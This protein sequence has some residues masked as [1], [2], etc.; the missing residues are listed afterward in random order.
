MLFEKSL[1][2]DAERKSDTKQWIYLI[3][4]YYY[5]IDIHIGYYSLLQYKNN[6]K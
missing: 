5:S 2:S 3:F 4:Y 6:Y 1:I